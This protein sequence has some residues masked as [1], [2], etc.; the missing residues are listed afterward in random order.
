MFKMLVGAPNALR[1]VQLTEYEDDLSFSLEQNVNFF[2][3]IQN[4]KTKNNFR[5]HRCTSVFI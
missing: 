4:S 5:Q 1:T 3:S 2:L